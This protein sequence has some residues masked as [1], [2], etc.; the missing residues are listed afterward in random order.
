[1]NG[2]EYYYTC[3]LFWKEREREREREKH[4]K[5]KD[6]WKLHLLH[7]KN[8]FLIVLS[9]NYSKD[10]SDNTRFIKQMSVAARFWYLTFE[11]WTYLAANV[12]PSLTR[13]SSKASLTPATEPRGRLTT[14][15]SVLL[16]NLQKLHRGSDNNLTQA[17]PCPWDNGSPTGQNTTPNK[18]KKIM[19]HISLNCILASDQHVSFQPQKNTELTFFKLTI[20]IK[21]I[22]WINFFVKVITF[23]SENF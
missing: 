17:R 8:N 18:Y 2:Y 3:I 10:R 21:A 12:W 5:F 6:I 4:C 16:L 22:K 14:S 11:I 23:F 7:S 19:S 1:M 9:L 13:Q 15:P 20:K